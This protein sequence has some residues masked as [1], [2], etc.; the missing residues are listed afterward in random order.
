LYTYILVKIVV[1]LVT[2][3][4]KPVLDV[5]KLVVGAYILVKIVGMKTADVYNLAHDG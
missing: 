2:D 5:Y 3:V 4:H 1:I